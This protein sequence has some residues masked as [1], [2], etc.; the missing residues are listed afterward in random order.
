MTRA[1]EVAQGEAAASAAA[2]NDES[3]R[4]GTRRRG[5]DGTRRRG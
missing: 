3:G 5:R 4:D 1:A 2:A